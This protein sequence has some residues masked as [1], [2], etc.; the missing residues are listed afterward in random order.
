MRH[1]V[2]VDELCNGVEARRLPAIGRALSVLEGGGPEGEALH[3]AV[4]G[5]ARGAARVLGITGPP[6]AGKSTLTDRLVAELRAADLRVAVLAVDPS[7]PFTGGALLGDRIRLR[8]RPDDPGLFWRSVA[9]RGA[10]GGLAPT[11]RGAIRVLDLAGYDRVLV[12]TVGVGQSE[13]EVAAVADCC[14]VVAVPGA[15]DGVQLMKA[16]L[17][18]VGDVYVV[19]KADEHGAAAERLCRALRI[20][21]ER[22]DEVVAVSALR[23]EGIETLVATTERWLAEREVSGALAARRREGL[24]REVLALVEAY[25]VAAARRSEGAL[26]AVIDGL[27]AGR[28]DPASAARSLLAGAQLDA[29]SA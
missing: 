13:I 9:S 10:L 6:G 16:G 1:P 12:E 22:P 5:R 29:G 20:A 2:T 19:N 24:E 21:L 11:I 3:A 7:S 27:A 25:A 4:F 8:E 15:G 28:G 18:E 23:G 14:V 17:L 26:T